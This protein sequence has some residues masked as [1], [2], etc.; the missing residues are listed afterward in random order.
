MNIL[1]DSDNFTVQKFKNNILNI[2]RTLDQKIFG[3]ILNFSTHNLFSYPHLDLDIQWNLLKNKTLNIFC[4]AL[5]VVASEMLWA[6]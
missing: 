1:C 2:D 3:N 5:S 4:A 6:N